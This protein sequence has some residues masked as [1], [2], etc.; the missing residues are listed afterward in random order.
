MLA[1]GCAA[2][3]TRD[4][5]VQATPTYTSPPV[6]AES[7]ARQ[8]DAPANH[9]DNNGWKRRK[10]LSAA[11]ER[12]GRELAARIRPPLE[13][14][15]AAGDFA[16]ASTQGALLDLGIQADAIEVTAMRPPIGQDTP[17][18]GAVYAVRF[19][20]VGCAIGA[21]RPDRVMV[22]VTGAA[23]EFGCLEPFSH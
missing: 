23:A 21:V 16:P 13:A 19:G 9:A 22:E 3:G 20:N 18:P 7:T 17:P 15:R 6:V 10:E 11:D 8:P 5:D 4:G 2:P 12:A 1:S 14:L